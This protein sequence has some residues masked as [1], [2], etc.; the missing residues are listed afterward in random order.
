MPRHP[1]H[2]VHHFIQEANIV[3]KK[4]WTP[5][6]LFQYVFSPFKFGIIVCI[7]LMLFLDYHLGVEITA[8]QH[9]FVTC[10]FHAGMN[11]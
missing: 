8:L 9:P 6:G 4:G 5:A 2:I 11:E 7:L 3:Q 1:I 10:M